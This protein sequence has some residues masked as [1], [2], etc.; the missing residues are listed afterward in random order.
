MIPRFY[1]RIEFIPL[2]INGKVNVNELPDIDL[3]DIDNFRVPTTKNEKVIATILSEVLKIDYYKV[4]VNDSFFTL[5]GNS[6]LAISFLNKVNKEL[7]SN[8]R[9]SDLHSF[10]TISEFAASIES[11]SFNPVVLFNNSKDYS[12]NIIMIHPGGAGCEVYSSLCKQLKNKF[13]CL[14]IDS[15]NLYNDEKIS[16][17]RCLAQYYLDKL[18]NSFKTE[19]TYRFLGWS[20]GGLI[21]L[22]M[23]HILEKKG[24]KNIHVYLLDTVIYDPKLMEYLAAQNNE[25]QDNYLESLNKY[26]M[27]RDDI[28]NYLDTEGLISC[29]QISG[30]LKNTQVTLYKAKKGD[31][32][33]SVKAN[34]YILNLQY[35][36]VD[37]F[38]DLNNLH[39]VELRNC[40]HYDILDQEQLIVDNILE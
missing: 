4:N 15:Y 13:N 1:C 2:T 38:T 19:Q 23:A 24:I 40:C 10:H 7:D 37:K 16:D 29:Q 5:G 8:C 20:L 21:A 27:G 34:S 25:Y 6:I 33:L 18:H 12:K 30:K 26:G 9:I 35:N 17:L 11:A 32:S 36:N 3:E 14:G 39:L 31:E 28:R 22:E